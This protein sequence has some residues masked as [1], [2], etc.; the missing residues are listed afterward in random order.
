[1]VVSSNVAVHDFNRLRERWRMVI[2][3]AP[4]PKRDVN[5]WMFCALDAYGNYV[6][7]V[8][9]S[10]KVFHFFSHDW[11]QNDQEENI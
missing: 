3:F 10:L 7:E 6:E 2:S 8:E 5:S 4:S 11:S 9:K 1:M